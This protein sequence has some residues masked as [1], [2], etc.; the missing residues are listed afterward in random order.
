MSLRSLSAIPLL[1]LVP[2]ACCANGYKEFYKPAQG[3]TPE[4]I[5]AVRLAPAPPTPIVE[6]AQ[7]G[8]AQVVL[9]AYAKRGYVMIGSSMFNSG[10]AQS[11]ESAVHQAQSVGAD[12]VLIL[13]PRYTGSVTS[14]IP[15]TTPTTTTSYSTGTATAYGSRGSVTAYGSGT[16]TTYGSTTKYVPITINKSDYGAVYFV[17]RRFGFGVFSRDLNDSERQNLQTNKGVVI[18]LVVDG[19]PGFDADLLVGD[20]ITTIDSV[21]VPSSQVLSDLLQERQGKSVTFAII[22]RGQRMEKTVRLDP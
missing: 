6:R 16:K 10:P 9:D 11:E 12:L 1:M 21:V 22:R 4:A 13:N 15:I 19:T 7:P 20:V 18:R 3:A 17:K 14:T 2:L 5:A 8:E